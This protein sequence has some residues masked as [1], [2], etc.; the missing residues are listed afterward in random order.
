MAIGL[1]SPDVTVT[2]C[3]EIGRGK[4]IVIRGESPIM[5][6]WFIEAIRRCFQVVDKPDDP[7]I[8]GF[9]ALSSTKNPDGSVAINIGNPNLNV[10]RMREIKNCSNIQESVLRH[11]AM[12]IWYKLKP[13]DNVTERWGWKEDTGRRGSFCHFLAM[14]EQYKYLIQT[15]SV[16]GFREW[17]HQQRLNNPD[18]A[19]A[20]DERAHEIAVSGKTADD[21]MVNYDELLNDF[22]S[23][24]KIV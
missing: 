7:Y 14:I 21:L 17:Y 16:G 24:Y 9:S 15:N 1:T 10:G 3:N 8:A 11:E 6:T 4:S 23:V 22:W 13:G 2:D 19:L 12:E 20:L 18:L 5:K